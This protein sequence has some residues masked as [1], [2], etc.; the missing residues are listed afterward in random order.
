MRVTTLACLTRC[1]NLNF[2]F[3]F[4]DVLGTR[5]G[6]LVTAQW[7]LF[8]MMIFRP[9]ISAANGQ[10][11]TPGPVVSTVVTRS[12]PLVDGKF[13]SVI[14]VTDPSLRTMLCL[15]FGLFSRVKFGV[16]WAPPVSVVPFR[17][18]V[19]FVVVMNP[20]LPRCRLVSRLFGCPGWFRVLIV[21][22]TI[23]LSGIGRTRLVFPELLPMLFRF[24]A[25]LLVP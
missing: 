10:L 12:D 4:R 1:R 24:T 5:L 18:F 17:L 21:V 3:P 20:L 25:L 19:L 8:V 15:L 11:V 14:L 9:G 13:I 2:R 6:M 22:K 7:R 16:W 23:A